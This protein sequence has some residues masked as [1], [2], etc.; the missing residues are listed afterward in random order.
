MTSWCI[1]GVIVI[2]V[3]GYLVGLWDAKR[4]L[5]KQLRHGHQ[6]RK[7]KPGQPPNTTTGGRR[8]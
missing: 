4:M 1:T 6:P 5:D 3:A 2:L 7:C 8:K